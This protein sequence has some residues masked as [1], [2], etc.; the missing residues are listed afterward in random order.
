MTMDDEGGCN[1]SVLLKRSGVAFSTS[2]LAGTWSMHALASG[3]APSWLGWFRMDVAIGSDGAVSSIAGSYKNSSGET[4]NILNAAFSLT[5]QGVVE[6]LG[7]P[8]AH[9]AMSADKTLM[10]MTMNDGGGG[11]DLV[12]AQKHS[13][14]VFTPV[15]LSGTW[16]LHSLTSGDTP[17]FVG[18]TH[19]S[20]VVGPNGFFALVPDSYRNSSGGTPQVLNGTLNIT[21]E[22][23]VTIA[24]EPSSHGFMSGDRSLIV[25]TMN[26][27]GGGYDLA[28]MTRI[29][30]TVSYADYTPITP[31]GH[32][33]KSWRYTYGRT[34]VWTSQVAGTV[35]V[36]YGDGSQLT[37]NEIVRIVGAN[38]TV[39]PEGIVYNDG[40]IVKVLAVN[41]AYLSSDAQ[42]TS[43][44]AGFS[45]GLITDGMV[46]DRCP[47][48]MVSTNPWS[49]TKCE[50]ELELFVIHDVSVV[51]GFYRDA[52]VRWTIDTSHSYA[53]LQF[54]GQDAD[55]G[56][57]LP[58]AIQTGGY[59]ISVFRIYGRDTTLIA[60]GTVDP[61]T[62][63]LQSVAEVTGIA[64]VS[65]F[66][67]GGAIYTDRYNPYGSGLANVR[68]VVA[69][70]GGTF[71]TTTDAQGTWRVD[72]I[73]EAVY[74]VTP[75]KGGYRF[76][77]AVGSTTDGQPFV[78]T[79]IDEAHRA[80]NQNLQFVAQPS[81]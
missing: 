80:A 48:Y 73:S 7:K 43:H 17:M 10:A 32:G 40:T 37:A 54:F 15:D 25:M 16:S 22:G 63:Q 66:T 64:Q 44:A 29:G 70:P 62:G 35:T 71:E 4:D 30:K 9:G 28:I 20:L 21:G 34:G 78:K 23:V 13:D 3:D 79:W 74:T 51:Q 6:I 42:L 77:H 2:D 41:D 27:G 26:D 56:I 1:L 58:N 45:F 5:N 47:Y 60:F 50:N 11:Y 49:W 76:E 55:L 52:I 12:I 38:R 19:M 18:W 67:I 39:E 31:Q 59:S 72:K 24:G 33:I 69:G 57:V 61:G 75:S 53:D 46:Y 65:E 68:V 14:T 81:Q 8:D 36:Q